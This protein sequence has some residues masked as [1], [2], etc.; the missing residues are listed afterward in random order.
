MYCLAK[1]G[2]NSKFRVKLRKVS[3]KMLKSQKWVETI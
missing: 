1:I 2:R 3:W